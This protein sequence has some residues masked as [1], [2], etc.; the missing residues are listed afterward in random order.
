MRLGFISSG[1]WNC[2]EKKPHRGHDFRFLGGGAESFSDV[3]DIL[4][5]TTQNQECTTFPDE[6]GELCR[7]SFHYVHYH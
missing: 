7:E 4:E 1:F 2:L 5:S 3:S 6:A